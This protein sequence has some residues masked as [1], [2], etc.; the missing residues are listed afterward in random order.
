MD[1][2]R[3]KTNNRPHGQLLQLTEMG[4]MIH[5]WLEFLGTARH[6][7]SCFLRISA[8]SHDPIF[9]L[10]QIQIIPASLSTWSFS[11]SLLALV[12]LVRIWSGWPTA[13][14]P[15]CPAQWHQMTSMD[16]WCFTL[17]PGK[18]NKSLSTSLEI[19]ACSRRAFVTAMLSTAFIGWFC[20]SSCSRRSFAMWMLS[21]ALMLLPKSPKQL[22]TCGAKC[23]SRTCI[24]NHKLI[25]GLQNFELESNLQHYS[26]L[27][28]K[29]TLPV[30]LQAFFSRSLRVILALPYG[31]SCEIHIPPFSILTPWSWLDLDCTTH[32]AR[33]TLPDTLLCHG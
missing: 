24:N 6:D 18:I 2:F 8:I 20:S 25:S 1:L 22:F 33:W 26:R 13:K 7:A 19:W 17:H 30:S 15:N 21:T 16:R 31:T 28:C 4:H 5:S 32:G 29:R 12:Q 9:A 23:P 11:F 27:L 10:L 3:E 14:P